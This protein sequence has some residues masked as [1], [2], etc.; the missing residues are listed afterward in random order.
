MS[1]YEME[2]PHEGQ[3]RSDAMMGFPQFGQK[4]ADFSL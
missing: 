1:F 4:P 2:F 3:K